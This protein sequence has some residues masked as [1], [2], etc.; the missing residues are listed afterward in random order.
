MAAAFENGV[1]DERAVR[2]AEVTRNVDRAIGL[3][4]DP[5]SGTKG[6]V[7]VGQKAVTNAPYGVRSCPV[8]GFLVEPPSEILEGRTP[9]AIRG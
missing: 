3:V 5:D 9:R 8:W 2:R 1:G 4:D 6:A 7:I